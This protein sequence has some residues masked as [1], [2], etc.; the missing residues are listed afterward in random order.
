MSS[1]MI[2]Q[3]TN[4]AAL[5]LLIYDQILTWDKEVNRIWFS[6][7][8]VLKIMF[9]LGRYWALAIQIINLVAT[10]PYILEKQVMSCHKW[11]GFQTCAVVLL[12]LNLQLILKLRVYALYERSTK[13]AVFLICGFL[14]YTAVML[15][16][17]SKFIPV[18][19]LDSSCMVMEQPDHTTT[20]AFCALVALDFVTLWGLTT[21]K[22]RDGLRHG[23]STNPI[24][25]LVMRDT[26][27]SCLAIVCLFIALLP[28]NLIVQQVGHVI[29]SILCS[30]V[31]V[32]TCRTILN[33][34]GLSDSDGQLS[35]DITTVDIELTNLADL[36]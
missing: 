22:Y 5:V 10:H 11:F 1:V 14:C 21:N 18:L 33:M 7:D 2:R 8:W 20:I 16:L 12:L 31:S 19:Q 4:I 25:R 28:Y 23:W 13:M 9:F 34:R 17:G 15:W 32:I 6:S 24:L 36:E 35:I 3:Y 30:L 27:W 29:Y 26:T